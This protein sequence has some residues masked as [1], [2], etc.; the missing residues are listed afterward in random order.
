MGG[1]FPA[2]TPVQMAD[3]TER[4]IEQIPAGERIASIDEATG[5]RTTAVVLGI[6]AHGVQAS[7]AGLVRV[8]GKI[9]VTPDHPLWV[10]GRVVHAGDLKLGDPLVGAPGSG[11]DSVRSLEM[12]PGGVPVYDLHLEG[13]KVYI[14]G[15]SLTPEEKD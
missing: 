8:N 5:E 11:D 2:G 4:P 7:A 10:G 14:V 1:C 6:K 15:G 9:L 3:G 13:S 12:M